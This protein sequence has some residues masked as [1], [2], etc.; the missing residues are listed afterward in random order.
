MI[1]IVWIVVALAAILLIYII[2]LLERDLEQAKE[3]AQHYSQLYQ[4][5]RMEYEIA[6]I[7]GKKR[8]DREQKHS[9]ANEGGIPSKTKCCNCSQH[10]Q[11]EAQEKEIEGLAR[12]PFLDGTVPE[13]VWMQDSEFYAASK[14][15]RYRLH[16]DK[17]DHAHWEELANGD[18]TQVWSA[19]DDAQGQVLCE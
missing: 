4:T 10:R 1:F 11:E 12:F 7:E 3:R 6:T 17:N 8:E 14:G 15:C 2:Y 9:Q 16:F 5:A 18:Q 13:R 19:T